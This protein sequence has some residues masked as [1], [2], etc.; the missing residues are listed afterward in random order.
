MKHTLSIFAVAIAAAAAA[1]HLSAAGLQITSPAFSHNA[2][3]PIKYSC[4]GE[5]TNPPLVFGGVPA[6]AKSLALIVEDPDVPKTLRPNGMFDHWVLWD[7]APTT[8]GL[9]E[10]ERKADG[11]NGTGKPGW[12]P[13]CPPDR[14]HRYFFKLYALDTMIGDRK[15]ASKEDLLAAMQG[16]ILEQAE[17]VGTYNKQNK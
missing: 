14:E 3:I 7:L 9:A 4:E 15:I 17:L 5:K 13:P 1:L 11:L 10:G 16:H 12:V 2:P 8:K 6:G